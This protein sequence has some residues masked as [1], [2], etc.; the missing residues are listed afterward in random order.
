MTEICEG[1]IS[2]DF[3][4]AI[5][6]Q[7]FDSK[8]NNKLSHCMA[9]VDIIVEIKSHILFIEVKD[10]DHP[11]ARASDRAEF[12]QKLKNKSH[13]QGFARKYRDS[14]IYQCA[15][16]AVTKPVKYIVLVLCND[17]TKADFSAATSDLSRK[18][19]TDDYVP[20]EWHRGICNNSIILDYDGWRQHFP[21]LPIKCIQI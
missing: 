15:K 18:I 5:M 19:P 4:N 16:R 20:Q 9:A 1:R 13:I 3:S 2:I 11:Q 8:E 10:P 7:K 14:Y 6:A 17:L 21:S 12:I